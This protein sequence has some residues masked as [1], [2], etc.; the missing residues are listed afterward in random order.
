MTLRNLDQLQEFTS[1]LVDLHQQFDTLI[2][3][4]IFKEK[5]WM[6]LQLTRYIG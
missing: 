4:T 3:D 5:Y 2:I 1:H 6:P